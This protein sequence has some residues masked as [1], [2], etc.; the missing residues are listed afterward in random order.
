ME[1][2]L[3]AESSPESEIVTTLLHDGM[4]SDN[5]HQGNEK[6]KVEFLVKTEWKPLMIRM[7]KK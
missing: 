7:K 1:E 2:T 4:T 6:D 3:E 5:E